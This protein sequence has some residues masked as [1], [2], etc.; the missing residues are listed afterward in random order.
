MKRIKVNKFS[1][2]WC[3]PCK[4]MAKTFDK[5]KKLPEFKDVEFNE[6]DVDD[7][8]N[9]DI[10]KK[11]YI[12]NIPA[13]VICDENNEQLSKIIGVVNENLL[14]QAINDNMKNG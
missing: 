6:Y 14:V 13:I 11:F 10:L 12:R 7:E 9:D 4:V 5:I 2:E 3:G 8:S 1:A